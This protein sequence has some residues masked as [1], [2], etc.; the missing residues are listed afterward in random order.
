MRN[1]KRP[2]GH[3]KRLSSHV[4]VSSTE[5][6]CATNS[7]MSK[8]E[9]YTLLTGRAVTETRALNTK[10]KDRKKCE[11]KKTGKRGLLHGII[12]R[13][14]LVDFRRR[15]TCRYT[16]V[17]DRAFT[18]LRLPHETAASRKDSCRILVKSY[19]VSIVPPCAITWI[20]GRKCCHPPRSSNAYPIFI[21]PSLAFSYTHTH[22]LARARRQKT[23]C[24]TF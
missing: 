14:V 20:F 18:L 3:R 23:L 16:I 24:E 10:G 12:S 22:T 11:K 17:A 6:E 9:P 1:N 8:K 21:C 4:F 15:E 7:S 19:H 5:K 13:G 2:A